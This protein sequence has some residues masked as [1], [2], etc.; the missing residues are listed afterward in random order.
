[1]PERSAMTLAPSRPIQ[2]QFRWYLGS[3]PPVAR[4][5]AF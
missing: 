1:M 3:V 2:P 4:M 5:R